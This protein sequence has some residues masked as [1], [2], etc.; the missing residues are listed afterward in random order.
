MK[1]LTGT[2]ISAIIKKELRVYFNSPIAY[3][4]IAAL[5]AFSFWL[6]FKNYFLIGQND[7]RDFFSILPWI[8]LFLIPALTMRL[9]SEEYRQGTVETLLTSSIPL[10]WVVLGKFFASAF[11]F[12]IALLLTVTL[13]LTLS[14]LGNL[15]WG[16]V[17][18]A[19][20]GAFL[21]GSAYIALGLAISSI[22]NNQIVAFIITVIVSFAFLIIG[23]P[24]ITYAAPSFL[25]PILH[26]ISLGTHF[27]S[28]IR[29]VIDTRDIIYYLSFIFLF[30][31]CNYLSLLSRK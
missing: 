18:S 3:I 20:I 16:V 14:A 4:F 27:N 7:M 29:G 19:Y 10:R 17:F 6:F 13:P 31:Y 8:F 11:F 15:D 5:I 23:D 26:S 21:L 28:V 22:T 25:V 30:L 2:Q 1:K 9:W 12:L 24:I